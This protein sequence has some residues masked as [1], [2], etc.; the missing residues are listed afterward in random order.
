MLI[1]VVDN[2]QPR[3]REF[4]SFFLRDTWRKDSRRF[5]HSSVNKMCEAAANPPLNRRTREKREKN[6]R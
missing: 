2:D 5:V 3:F 4:R 1:V 6:A